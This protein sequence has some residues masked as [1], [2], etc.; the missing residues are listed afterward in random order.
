MPAIER[1]PLRLDAALARQVSKLLVFLQIAIG[2]IQAVRQVR[3]RISR[4]RPGDAGDDLFLSREALSA[5]PG[6]KSE[7]GGERHRWHV[8]G[9]FA[10][11]AYEG[12][13]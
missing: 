9:E 10:T 11:D 5:A 3:R 8:R 1:M 12:L 7:Y 13:Q 2:V 4:P 6:F